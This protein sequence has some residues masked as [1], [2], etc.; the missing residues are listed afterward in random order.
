MTRDQRVGG[1]YYSSRH[2]GVKLFCVKATDIVS[3]RNKGDR[4]KKGH[5]STT[6]DS[7]DDGDDQVS[8]TTRQ[9]SRFVKLV[10]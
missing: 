5:I 8:K 3:L 1:K 10:A 6:R 2:L 9:T 7:T 4:D